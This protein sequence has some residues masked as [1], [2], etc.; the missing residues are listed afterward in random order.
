MTFFLKVEVSHNIITPLCY[1]PSL[2]ACNWPLHVRERGFIEVRYSGN[3]DAQIRETVNIKN[4]LACFMIRNA[5]SLHFYGIQL[6]YYRLKLSSLEISLTLTSIWNYFPRRSHRPARSTRASSP[7]SWSTRI[8]SSYGSCS[9]ST[10]SP[11]SL[12]VSLSLV[13]S[14]GVS[15]S[16]WLGFKSASLCFSKPPGTTQILFRY[17]VLFK[18]LYE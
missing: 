10:A 17:I 15:G 11:P 8:G 3:V 5:N 7:Q 12:F 13:S 9:S 4:F 6:L 16:D 14:T 1:L 2:D 18:I